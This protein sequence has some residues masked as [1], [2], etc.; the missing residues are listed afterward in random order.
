MQYRTDIKI[1]DYNEAFPGVITMRPSQGFAGTEEQGH[2]F[3]ETRQHRSKIKGNWGN[4]GNFREQGKKEI[5]I[6]I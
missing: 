1:L 4:K 6:L 5:N 2:L 3:Q